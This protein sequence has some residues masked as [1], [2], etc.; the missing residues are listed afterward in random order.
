[1]PRYAYAQARL[2]ARHGQRADEQLWRRLHGTDD[3]ANYLQMARQTVLRPW[4][5]GIDANHSSHAIEFSLRRQF[6]LYVDGVARWLAADWQAAFQA[7]H[8]LPD[9]PTVQHLLS[10][11]SAPAWLLEDPVLRRFASEN[12]R[13][14]TQA[15]QASEFSYLVQAWRRGEA[16]YNA[17]YDAWR[18]RWPGPDRLNAGMERLGRLLLRHIRSQGVNSGTSTARQ[19]QWLANKLVAGFRNYSFQPATAFYHLALVALDLER[20]RGDLLRRKLFSE[21]VRVA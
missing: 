12:I 6:R 16:L 2:Q 4:V 7:L 15:L 3:L 21:N 1:M 19:R 8:H 14:R 17:W 18:Q 20:L 9:L 10:G 11:E 13:L 5:N